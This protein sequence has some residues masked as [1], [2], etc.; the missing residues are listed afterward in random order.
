MTKISSID[1][2]SRGIKRRS[3]SQSSRLRWSA[4]KIRKSISEKNLDEVFAV[5]VSENRVR[6]HSVMNTPIRNKTDFT[7]PP[8]PGSCPERK[9]K[10]TMVK[11]FKGFKSIKSKISKLLHPGRKPK[12]VPVFR[13]LN[14]KISDDSVVFWE[15][16]YPDSPIPSRRMKINKIDE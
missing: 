11:T 13:T 6:R 1:V 5:E 2:Q 15:E 10:T 14:R 16:V 8:C 9:Q 7:T 12:P 4:T 3:K